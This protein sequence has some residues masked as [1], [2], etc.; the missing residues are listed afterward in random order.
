MVK[1]HLR[2]K[3]C[4][5]PS[6]PRNR[7]LKTAYSKEYSHPQFQ[8]PQNPY[9]DWNTGKKALTNY[10]DI[11]SKTPKTLTGIETGNRRSI[12]RGF[13]VQVPKPPKPLQGLKPRVCQHWLWTLHSSKTPKTLTGIETQWERE[14]LKHDEVPKPPKPLQGLK[15]RDRWSLFIGI[16]VPKPPKPLQGLKPLLF[17]LLLWKR[18]VPKPPKPL[19]GLK[20][21]AINLFGV[22]FH[23]PKPPK[24]LQGLKQRIG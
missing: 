18:D 17:F 12:V 11:C 21:L 16:A 10:S 7:T 9:R 13:P 14:H 5:D 15:Q 4:Y 24:P 3:K 22:S 1:L 23:V 2:N 19:Q 6:N 8:N 20:R